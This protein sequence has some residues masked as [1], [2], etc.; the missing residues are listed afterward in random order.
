MYTSPLLHGS[1]GNTTGTF[2]LGFIAYKHGIFAHKPWQAH[3]H[4]SV[5][6]SALCARQATILRPYVAASTANIRGNARES[7]PAGKTEKGAA[8]D[9][10]ATEALIQDFW[11]IA[12]SGKFQKLPALFAD[13]AI[14]HD[15]IFPRPIIGSKDLKQFFEM[16]ETVVPAGVSLVL[17]DTFASGLKGAARWHAQSSNGKTVPFSSGLSWYQMKRV[18]DESGESKLVIQEAWEYVEPFLKF[19]LV[20]PLI[21][22]VGSFFKRPRQ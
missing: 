10:A 18:L 21:S 1:S 11:E 7:G 12:S 17:D 20:L 16:I 8:L 22:R 6:K 9:S 2:S 5:G 4:L 15:G 14:Y 13:D 19:G 3:T